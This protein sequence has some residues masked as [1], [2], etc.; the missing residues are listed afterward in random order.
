MLLP[1]AN[2][3]LVPC[4]LLAVVAGCGSDQGVAASPKSG[5]G[6]APPAPESI[7][8]LYARACLPCHGTTAAPPPPSFP[9]LA[10]SEWLR[11]DPRRVVR[12]VLNGLAGPIVVR[13]QDYNG[14]MPA[15]GGQLGDEEIARLVNYV[16]LEMAGI[17]EP[18][19]PE[20]VAE[21]RALGP[22]GGETY[23]AAELLLA[24]PIED[25]AL[26]LTDIRH[27]E[28]PCERSIKSRADY[29]KALAKA[30]AAERLEPRENPPETSQL[31]RIDKF[32]G[33]RGKMQGLLTR[34]TLHVEEPGTYRL[35]GRFNDWAEITV[36]GEPRLVC[37]GRQ[38]KSATLSLA[39]GAHAL[40]LRQFTTQVHRKTSTLT[41]QL[42]DDGPVRPLTNGLEPLMIEPA[43]GRAAVYR[44]NLANTGPRSIAFGFPNGLHMAYDPDRRGAQLLWRGDFI[45][46]G[47]HFTDRG[48]GPEFVAGQRDVRLLDGV[49]RALDGH[50]WRYLGYVLDAAGMPT[51]RFGQEPTATEVAGASATLTDAWRSVDA[52]L[53][54]R[55]AVSGDGT[56][57][58]TLARKKELRVSGDGCELTRGWHVAAA[59]SPLEVIDDRLV[60]RVGAAAPLTL[61]YTVR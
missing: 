54:R 1:S 14:L 58:L 43:D 25:A 18:I 31:G 27:E 55:I 57:L 20:L 46:A 4:A 59:G 37:R 41:L 39:A 19:G 30:E 10:D 29:D 3:A 17:D 21:M 35:V 40:E 23:T 8:T 6:G 36:D 32:A 49:K 15:Q 5:A 48:Q 9:P 44:N 2:R 28:F 56:V 52:A 7:E 60:A 45:D 13:G 24:H 38:R 61:T 11:G 22:A 50:G 51:F 47:R 53:E 12:I 42:G 33:K 16:R 26:L 34:A